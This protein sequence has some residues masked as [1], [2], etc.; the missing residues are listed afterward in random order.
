MDPTWQI[1][2][3]PLTADAYNSP[4]SAVLPP[5]A[6]LLG[7][8]LF[9]RG[10]LFPLRRDGKGDFLT[11]NGPNGIRAMVALVLTTVARSGSE[12]LGEVPW[13]TEFGSILPLLRMRN[14][15]AALRAQAKME[16][17]EALARWIPAIQIND[18]IFEKGGRYKM[19]CKVLYDIVDTTG[20][21]VVVPGITA[22]VPIL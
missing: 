18:V 8:G 4:V 13:R 5:T 22:A 10:I 21:R 12:A 19:I 16:V 1:V 15:D 20:S 3:D 14:N 6:R 9:G 17:I 11:S 2:P 7:S